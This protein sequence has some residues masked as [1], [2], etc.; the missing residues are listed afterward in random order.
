MKTKMLWVTMAVLA[1]C[2]GVV[3][4]TEETD[5]QTQKLNMSLASQ[6]DVLKGLKYIRV[7]IQSLRPEVEKYGLTEQ[8]LQ[9]DVEL[10][11]RQN[12]I[13]VVSKELA[14]MAE[15]ILFLKVGTVTAEEIQLT[16]YCIE[17]QLKELVPLPRNPTKFI[18]ATTWEHGYIG[19][20]PVEKISGVR[21]KVKDL[22][23]IFINDYLAAN[24]RTQPIKPSKEQEKSEG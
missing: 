21:G 14:P 9:T 4:A 8:Q 3:W 1:V 6:R 22:V 17:V 23:D 19:I 13:E 15:A 12:G 7:F 16:G 18:F 5:S 24:P 11:L 2:I 10:R 20:T